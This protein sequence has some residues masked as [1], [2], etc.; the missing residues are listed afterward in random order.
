MSVNIQQI[1]LA[2]SFLTKTSVFPSNE[3]ISCPWNV[4]PVGHIDVYQH[5]EVYQQVVD[6]N[7]TKVSLNSFKP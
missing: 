4:N 6:V 3:M 7:K 1:S 5:I 2:L